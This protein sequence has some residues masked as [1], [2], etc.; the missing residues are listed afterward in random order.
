MPQAV[1]TEPTRLYQAPDHVKEDMLS[2][3][4]DITALETSGNW[5]F[6][7]ITKTGNLQESRRRER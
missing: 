7:A 3:N 1:A 4:W 6:K 5:R 2:Y